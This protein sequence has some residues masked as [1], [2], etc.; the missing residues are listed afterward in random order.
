MRKFGILIAIM[1]ICFSV[2]GIVSAQEDIT[3]HSY[4]K[5]CGMDR[6][7]FA[8]SRVFIEYEDGTTMGT[9]SIRCAAV[10]LLQLDK[11]PKNIWVGDY[12]TKQLLDAEKALW[13][14][15]GSKP[16]VMTKRAKWAFGKK[17]DVEQ[18][19][20]EFGGNAVAFDE[21]IK[22]AYEDIYADTK[23]IRDRRKMMQQKA[24]E[25]KH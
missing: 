10:D 25:H 8:H 20:K 1:V 14:L 23:M 7:K 6:S 2:T 19:M 13:V 5:Y 17:D 12:N 15:G 9:C 21:A 11:I 4:C 18:F 24:M 22:A 16:G 3:K